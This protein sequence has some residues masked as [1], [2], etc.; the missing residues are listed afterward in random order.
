MRVE[1]DLQKVTTVTTQASKEIA[2]FRNQIAN[3]L[4]EH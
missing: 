4:V 1:L 3:Y 2:W